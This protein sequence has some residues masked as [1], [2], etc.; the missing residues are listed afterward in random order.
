MYRCIKKYC[1][2]FLYDVRDVPDSLILTHPD[3]PKAVICY[4]DGGLGG[5]TDRM[6]DIGHLL[7]YSANQ[8][9]VLLFKWYEAPLDLEA[10]LQPHLL[11]WTLPYHHHHHH[12]QEEAYTCSSPGGGIIIKRTFGNAKTKLKNPKIKLLKNAR[13]SLGEY[14]EPFG[15]FWDVLFWPSER[16][17]ALLEDAITNNNRTTRT[18]CMVGY[19]TNTTTNNNDDT[20][21]SL[22]SSSSLS[23]LQTPKSYNVVH[24]RI[25]H[26]AFD[27]A[28]SYDSEQQAL[29][30]Q[31]GG[32]FVGAR[33]V[34]AI[35]SAVHAIACAQH[36]AATTTMKKRWRRRI[37]IIIS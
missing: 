28:I 19:D 27:N 34:Q 9:R 29:D 8:K 3:A 11:N 36:L 6:K 22:S 18:T 23:L 17:E 31:H 7:E 33:A 37:I 1:I 32:G 13:P 30:L 26:P 35:R 12:L 15:V 2:S 10:F 14:L 24:L 20:S 21:S 4:Q 5:L 16:V 25:G